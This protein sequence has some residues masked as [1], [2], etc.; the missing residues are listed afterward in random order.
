MPAVEPSCLIAP[1]VPSITG[2]LQNLPEFSDEGSALNVTGAAFG[3]STELGPNVLIGM[4]L[5]LGG[6]TLLLFGAY[7]M[8][9]SLFA[10][11]FV[12]LYVPSL[13]IGNAALSFF[14]PGGVGPEIILDPDLACNILI[15]MPLLLGLI[16]AAL[17][18]C[19][20]NLALWCLG[21]IVGAAVGQTMYVLLFHR[22]PSGH[23]LAG[24][25]AV[26]FGCVFGLALPGAYLM[27]RK[28]HQL[29]IIATSA[30]GA[31]ALVPGLAMSLLY[32]FDERFLWAVDASIN[33]PHLSSPFV[34]SQLLVAV[35]VYFPLGVA[36]QR[37][38]KKRQDELQ[39]LPCTAVA[40][41]PCAL[42]RRISRGIRCCYRWVEKGRRGCRHHVL[43]LCCPAKKS[44][45]ELELRAMK[46]EWG[47]V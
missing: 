36:C 16:G 20:V 10:V 40:R 28:K 34:C 37:Y 46:R 23:E 47:A 5:T 17:T 7:L 22:Y 31:A 30:V 43:P 45:E 11:G 21:F 35:L 15:I 12:I 1:L 39:E 42:V 24:Y 33:N 19:F 25:D 9:F 2:G 18:I 27:V 4:L 41:L 44:E 32:H 29:L 13:L 8:Q 26:W 38:T 6:V 3:V 14:S